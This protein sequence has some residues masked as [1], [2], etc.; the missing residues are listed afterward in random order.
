MTSSEEPTNRNVD[1]ED[2]QIDEEQLEEY[3]EMVENL[4]NFPVRVSAIFL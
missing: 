4:G 3:K 2:E 1:D